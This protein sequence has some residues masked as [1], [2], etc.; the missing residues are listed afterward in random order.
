MIPSTNTLVDLLRMRAQAHPERL[1][2]TYLKDG[3]EVAETWSYEELDRRARRV[4]STLSE[5]GMAGDRAILI[6]PPGLAF[7]AAFFGCLYAKRIAVPLSAP[8]PAR[9][10]RELPKLHSIL[11]S[12]A[13]TSLLTSTSML[14]LTAAFSAK[15]P[16][17]AR[18]RV[19]ATDSLD[20]GEFSFRDPGVDANTL[21]FLQYTSGSTALPKGVMV[22][23]GNLLHNMGAS[24][25]AY[26]SAEDRPMVSWLPVFHDMGLIGCV[27][28]PMLHGCSTI[29]MAPA[30]FLQRPVRWLQ[31]ISRFRGHTSGG[32]NFAYDLCVRRT[33]PEQRAQ[34]DLSSWRVAF[35]GAEP[36]RARTLTEFTRA[37]AACGFRPDAVSPCYG[38]AESTLMVTASSRRTLPTIV[39]FDMLE[40]ERGKA[41][42]SVNHASTARELVG[43]GSVVGGQR[44][45]IVDPERRLPLTD[46]EIGEIWVAGPSVAHGYWNLPEETEAT[47]DGMLADGDGPFMRT[48][49]LGFLSNG[50][51][52]IAG[53][54]K[55][56]IIVD[57]RNHYPQDIELTVEQSHAA[58]RPGCCA[59]FSVDTEGAERIVVVAEADPHAS[60]I[61]TT[62]APSDDPQTT[63]FRAARRAISTDHGVDLHQL[64]LVRPGTIPKTTSGKIR[65][66]ATRTAFLNNTLQ[67]WNTPTVRAKAG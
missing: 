16:S 30:A 22:S 39:P 54:R 40:L 25:T 63:L 20:E 33:T 66:R 5:S 52:F 45:L 42:P 58:F 53:R 38:L 60:T 11:G 67:P 1:A 62:S 46:G 14:P 24:A 32:P 41:V 47:F 23:H 12:A 21:A 2:F 44:L 13:P 27:L 34:L 28:Q 26:E 56:L 19:V 17:V 35:N 57:G 43:C 61:S 10:D 9:L 6:Y 48:G 49:D 36:V 18:L 65:R 51:L 15:E 3:E 55:D 8:N 50:E 64:V 7:I 4:A 31:A 59:A 29:L 37:F